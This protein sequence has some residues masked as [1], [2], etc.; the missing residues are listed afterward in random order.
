MAANERWNL[1]LQNQ[2]ILL[3]LLFICTLF[4]Y[5]SSQID[6][7][8]FSSC[9]KSAVP[10]VFDESIPRNGTSAGAYREQ[11]DVQS[12]QDCIITCCEQSDCHII[13]YVTKEDGSSCYHVSI[14]NP[15]NLSLVL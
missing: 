9:P 5:C 4:N 2:G 7:S 15:K 13:L 12:L 1:T 6:V 14:P 3:L 11:N 8:P 10:E